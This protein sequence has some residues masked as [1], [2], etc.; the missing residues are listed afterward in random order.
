MWVETREHPLPKLV[1]HE[2]E[3]K[4]V[5]RNSF[6]LP[7]TV[8]FAVLQ[9][10][11]LLWLK[12]LAPFYCLS[13]PAPTFSCWKVLKEATPTPSKVKSN[14]L[15]SNFSYDKLGGSRT[16]LAK[17]VTEELYLMINKKFISYYYYYL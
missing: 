15:S 8:V 13:N 12:S 5:N 3:P 7:F 9:S 1:R 10:C 4:I 16:I 14:F 11:V 2:T 17:L 6:Q